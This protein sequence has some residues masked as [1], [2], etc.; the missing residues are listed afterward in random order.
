MKIWL[1]MLALGLILTLP[2]TGSL[3]EDGD[4]DI[5]GWAE[6]QEAATAQVDWAASQGVD[7]DT[8]VQAE[9]ITKKCKLKVSE[10]SRDKLTNGRV[11]SPWTYDHSDAW[12]GIQLPE[13]VTPGA[14]RIEWLFD[15]TG[16]EL[17]EYDASQNVLRTRTQADTFPGIYTLYGLLPE[18]RS[19]KLNMTARDQGV[20]NLVVYSAGVL[21]ADVQAWLPPVEKADIMVFST[22]QDDEVIFLGGTIPYADVVCGRPTITVYMTNCSRDRRREAL[23]CLWEM[24]S[25]HYPEFINLKDDKVSSIEKGVKLWGGR[26]N[27]LKEIVARIRRYKPEVIVT[28]DLDGEYGHN[29]HKILA[30]AMQPAIEAAADPNQFPDS[31][32]LYGA[33][34]VKKLYLHLYKE[35]QIRMDWVS[36]REELGGLS[37]LEVARN[38]MKKHASQTKYYTVKDGGEYDNALY[39][40]ALTTVGADVEK[41]DFFEN[42]PLSGGDADAAA[43]P[44][45]GDDAWEDA[46]PLAGDDMTA[47]GD[48][49]WE[50]AETAAAGDANPTGADDAWEDAA[51]GAAGEDGSETLSEDVFTPDAGP[52]PGAAQP[53]TVSERGGSGLWLLLAGAG[54]VA[55]G[56]GAWAYLRQPPKKSR[57]KKRKRGHKKSSGKGSKKKRTAQ[58]GKHVTK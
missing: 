44:A 28:Q 10:G 21:P 23:E 1:R 9:N 4:D 45:A 46:E 54:L 6:A 5:S 33:W 53:Q 31:Y 34:Q 13:G 7:I 49:A 38:G 56:A 57:R 50:D 32:S 24:G 39:G 14:I 52:T 36:P 26:D 47:T 16:Y 43:D 19:I 48:D 30:R 20:S 12:V 35:N 41:N 58:Q 55:I 11:G 37:L 40:L 51:S 3:A 25:R 27:I 15:P 42:I 18:T 17:I 8:S 22:H 2:M 29:Q